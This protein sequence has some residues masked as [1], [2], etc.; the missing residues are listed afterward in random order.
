MLL[1]LCFSVNLTFLIFWIDTYR[2]VTIFY[3]LLRFAI[4]FQLPVLTQHFTSNNM[5]TCWCLIINKTRFI[6]LINKK[7]L[8]RPSL[9]S[10]SG[11]L[12]NMDPRRTADLQCMEYAI[13]VSN[14][15][16]FSKFGKIELDLP[17]WL[18]GNHRMAVDYITERKFKYNTNIYTSD[19]LNVEIT[20]FN[21]VLLKPIPYAIYFLHVWKYRWQP[22]P[23]CLQLGSVS[24]FQLAPV[25][26]YY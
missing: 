6:R 17:T 23:R 16:F 18:W 4:C 3:S 11:T 22:R 8:I 21:S 19:L 26:W 24:L 25:I 20:Y 15:N 13:F 9:P 10:Q 14:S 2:F 5:S 12:C 7:I 1:Q